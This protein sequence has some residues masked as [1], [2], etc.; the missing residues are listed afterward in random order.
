MKCILRDTNNNK[1]R[2]LYQIPV[3]DILNSLDLLIHIITSL[4]IFAQCIYKQGSRVPV[5][6]HSLL[7]VFFLS[8][9]CLDHD[10]RNFLCFLFSVSTHSFLKSCIKTMNQETMN[11]S[12]TV[13]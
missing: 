11:Q 13:A 8:S 6:Y 12:Q 1:G 10:R 2:S 5:M 3:I 4:V 9:A 7:L